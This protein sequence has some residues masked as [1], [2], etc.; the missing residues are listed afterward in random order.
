M[1]FA[2]TADD[3]TA[4][5]DEALAEADALLEQVVSAPFDRFNQVLAPLDEAADVL[6][7]AYGRGAFLADVHPD[8]DLRDVA[9]A[10]QERIQQWQ[11]AMTF[12]DDLWTAISTYAESD[13]AAALDGERA[14][15]LAFMLRDLRRAGHELDP[16][17]RAEMQEHSGRLVEL[18]VAFQRN[19]AEHEDPLVVTRDDLAG[20][21]DSYVE[22]LSPGPDD[23]TYLVTL[24]YPDAIPF[25]DRAD[26]RDL[27]QELD[28]RFN[29]R[30]EEANRP[31][32]AEAVRLRARIAELLG[33]PSW[34][35]HKLEERMAKHPDAV[36]ELY[37]GIV[38]PLTDAAR[39]ELA[40]MQRLLAADTGDDDA[41]VQRWDWRY[42]HARLQREQHGIDNDEVAAHFPLEQVLDGLFTLTGDV[43]GLDHEP[44]DAE[45]WHPDVRSFTVRDRAS[46]E[47][48]ATVHMDL[49]PRE[50]TYGHAAAFTLRPGRRLPDGGYQQPVSAIV[51]NF[52]PPQV[53]GP[54]ADRPSL[55]QHSEVE[56]LFH[57]YGHI[58]HQVL[59]R[60]E[61]VRFSGTS[62][63]R[64]FVEAPSQIMQH[65]TWDPAVLRTFARHHETGE[66]IP[67][68]LVEALVAA[69]R[70]DVALQQLRQVQ[71]G[72]LDLALHG[73]DAPDLDL[74]EVTRQAAAVTL[75]P[76]PED[77]FFPATF[78]HVMGGYDAGYYGYIWAEVIGDDMFRR[79][80]EEGVTSPEVGADYR[81]EILEPGGSRDAGDLVRAFLGR[82]PDNTAFLHKLGISPT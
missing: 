50:G 20:L 74:D 11:V 8:P 73:E 61:L 38:P 51:A 45:T 3:V 24:S 19:L 35:H 33:Q 56:T 21:P 47:A 34:A 78:A 30:A 69:R 77:T 57:E 12:R 7:R 14:R 27:R 37:D 18:G 71:F 1:E 75:L 64:D 65:W 39:D 28:R 55:L 81:H 22:G 59:T 32:L 70:L 82:E 17:A 41:V 42:Y 49:F 2:R 44:A 48:I 43:F 53:G 62:V 46:G 23:G 25:L 72:L 63:E 52:T 67:D 68:E 79:F 4:L 40:V 76:H 80:A 26:R 36:R 5:T 9:R 29:T 58:L 15:L 13:D 54:T 6:G 66:P 16:D 31:L 10:A 60:A